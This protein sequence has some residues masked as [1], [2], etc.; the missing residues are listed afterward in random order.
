MNQKPNLLLIMTDQQK[1]TSLD[2]YS[3]VNSIQTTALRRLAGA[4]TTF[5]AGYCAYPLC[6]PSRISM[7]TGRYPSNSGFV[8]NGPMLCKGDRHFDTIF[9]AAKRQGCRTMLV[10]KDHAYGDMRNP[11]ALVSQVFDRRY[12]TTHGA[13]MTAQTN[14]DQPYVEEWLQSAPALKQLWGSAVAPW[15]GDASVSARMCEIACE[16]LEQWHEGDKPDGTPF[17][18]WLSFPDPHELYQAPRDVYDAIDPASIDLYPN[19]PPRDMES[20]AEY[21]QFMHW[22]FNAG[23]P[24][25][26]VKLQLI[27]VYLAMCKNV[28]NQLNRVF[29]CLQR[30]G[31]WENT[32]IVYVSDHGDL[33]GEHGLLQKF[34]CGYDGCARVPFLVAQPGVA[35]SAAGARSDEPVNL[36]DL[37]ATLCELLEWPALEGDQGRSFAPIVRGERQERLYTVVE[38]GVAGESLTL[39]D[40]PNFADHRFD[41]TPEGRWIYDPPHRFGGRMFAVRSK[42]FKLIAREGQAREF[43]DLQNDPWETTNL[44]AR[45]EFAAEM[46]RHYDYLAEHL[47]RVAPVQPSSHVAGQDAFYRAGGEQTWQQS[48][49]AHRAK[50]R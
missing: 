17:A 18:M 49:A 3:D 48:L 19:Q 32:V 2:L 5:N 25:D 33:T 23:D 4:G 12:A 10:G 8:G 7:L 30:L 20:R 38:S 6:V 42:R 9:H 46:L 28:D 21:I 45:A 16:Y 29:D 14:R 11:P 31:E 27:R 40:V 36:A 15:N 43:Y 50:I 37:P 35:A 1:A 22:Y 44:A 13:R 39:A 34:N 41:V 47:G 24:P 26:E